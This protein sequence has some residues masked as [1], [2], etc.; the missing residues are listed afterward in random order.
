M[1]VRFGSPAPASSCHGSLASRGVLGAA[2]RQARIAA[3]VACG[4]SCQLCLF[5]FVLCVV[6]SPSRQGKQE[7]IGVDVQLRLRT[8]RQAENSTN[9]LP[10]VKL[11]Q[12]SMNL[13]F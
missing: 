8:Q 13:S 4:W 5:C 9:F 2:W 11:Y 6:S 3:H 12:L 1:H 7:V 10:V